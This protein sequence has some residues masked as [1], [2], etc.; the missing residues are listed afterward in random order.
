MSLRALAVPLALAALAPLAPLAPLEEA[1][2]SQGITFDTLLEEMLDRRALAEFPDPPYLALQSSS[3][4]PSSVAPNR[5]GWFANDDRGHYARMLERDGRR[6]GV[7]LDAEGPGAVVRIWS[8]NPAGVLRVYLDGADEAA[9]A[10]PMAALLGGSGPV[11]AQF[12]AERSRGFNLYLPIPF[13]RRC[14]ITCDEPEGLYYAVNHRAW[15]AGTEVAS[16]TEDDLSALGER[17][18][19]LG[20]RLLEAPPARAAEGDEKHYAFGGEISITGK[21][22]RA[23]YTGLSNHAPDQP[24]AVSELRLLARDPDP[25]DG[26]DLEQL[27]RRALL[28]LTFDGVDTVSVPLGDFFGSAPGLNPFHSFPM[29]VEENGMLTCRLLMPYRER[30]FLRVESLAPEPLEVKGFVTLV[31]WEWTPNSLYLHAAWRGAAAVPTRPMRDWHRVVV[32]G[33]GVLVGD[34]LAV[35]NPVKDWWGEGDEKIYVDGERFPSHFGT[36]T[37]DYYGYGWGSPLPFQAPFHN[38]TRCDG[39]GNF[40][41]TS[42]NRFRALDAIPFFARLELDLE[43]WHWTDD[44][45]VS[46]AATTWF[47]AD[48]DPGPDRPDPRTAAGAGVPALVYEPFRRPG[49]IEAEELE[50][51]AAS[52]GLEVEAQELGSEWSGERQLWVRATEVGQ[53]VELHVPVAEPGRWRVRVWPTRSWDY[54]RIAFSVDGVPAGEPVELFHAEDPGSTGAPRP[55]DLGQFDLAAGGF[56]LRAEVVGSH[57]DSRAPHHYFGLD[58]LTLEP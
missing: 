26:A 41:Y 57:P 24:H 21:E 43:V 54:G 5:D 13:A 28:V 12:A 52:P 6:E 15:P 27:L 53:F 25:T 16:L 36:G 37:E 20:D 32:E 51:T 46:L 19:E 30:A 44:I 34:M 3:R 2:A 9:I 49:A 7:L 14:V 22:G 50:V 4:D 42:L 10:E 38:Q 8:A 29:T 47:Y 17:L 56:V 39:P 11:P 48:L 1:G 18:G 31:P 40:G 33:R 58:C 35:G 23:Q 45:D 55:V